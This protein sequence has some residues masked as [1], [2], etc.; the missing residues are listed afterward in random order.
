VCDKGIR[1][2]VVLLL[3]PS[4][5]LLR[6]RATGGDACKW[7]MK[8]GKERQ[9]LGAEPKQGRR[10]QSNR[11][12]FGRQSKPIVKIYYGLRAQEIAQLVRLALNQ[13]LTQETAV[14]DSARRF[15]ILGY[16]R[17]TGYTASEMAIYL[18]VRGRV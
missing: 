1:Q 14:R 4:H 12:A 15:M 8:Q 5:P 3:Q 17:C 16:S 13:P 6:C 7:E 9:G 11:A 2:A 18:V 10:G